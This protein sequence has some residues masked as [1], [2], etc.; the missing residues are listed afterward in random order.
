MEK[1]T[2][3]YKNGSTTGIKVQPNT[4]QEPKLRKLWDNYEEI[5]RIQKSDRLCFVVAACVR[6][7]FRCISI[8]EFYYVKREDIWKPGRD[9]IILPVISPLGRTR[10]PDP[11][12][13]P[14]M[15]H[16]AKEMALAIA[17]AI[18]TALEMELE[19]DDN[20]VWFE[21]KLPK[22]ETDK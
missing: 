11:N 4:I 12:N 15:I 6:E 16:P 9:G 14:K 8:R 10:K 20:A 2:A 18:E 17:Q 19:D 5:A 21:P 22:K 13:P 7:G 1:V 3:K